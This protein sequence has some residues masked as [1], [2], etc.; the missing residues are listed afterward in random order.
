MIRASE[1]QR[2]EVLAQRIIN[3]LASNGQ[4][5]DV[6]ETATDNSG[7]LLCN[8]QFLQYA[9]L[10]IVASM[11]VLLTSEAAEVKVKYSDVVAIIGAPHDTEATTEVANGRKISTGF[12]VRDKIDACL[13]RL[14]RKYR[15]DRKFQ[16]VKV[17]ETARRICVYALN[18]IGFSAKHR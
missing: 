1:I 11:C 3:L 15:Q 4:S 6:V 5:E 12:M 17:D 18:G 10:T 9:N 8:H 16:K 2:E 14:P 7:Y 13:R